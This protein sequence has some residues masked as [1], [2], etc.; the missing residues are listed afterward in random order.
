MSSEGNYLW[1]LCRGLAVP[2]LGRPATPI[3]GSLT[4][5][6]ERRLLE[7]RLRQQALYDGLTGSPNRALFID[8]LTQA[9]ANSKRRANHTYT[10]LWL[11]LDGFK[12]IERQ[13]GPP[14][15]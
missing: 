11:D 8:R 12:D 2:G 14:D 9:L 4:D 15:G 6:T 3:V 5:I 1:L 10:V 13:P 7:E